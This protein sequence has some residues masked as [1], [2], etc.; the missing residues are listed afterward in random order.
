[1]SDTPIAE[2]ANLLILQE[3]ALSRLHTLA[4]EWRGK[5][6][7][8]SGFASRVYEELYRY[9]KSVEKFYSRDA[10]GEQSR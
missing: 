5:H 1:M 4:H 2:L 7:T 6:I 10:A 8:D 3:C 9:E